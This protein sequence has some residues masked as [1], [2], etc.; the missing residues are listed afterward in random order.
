MKNIRLTRIISKVNLPRTLSKNL[1]GKN[2]SAMHRKLFGLTIMLAGITIIKLTAIVSIEIVR[3]LGE[4]LGGGVHG[5]GVI[6]FI[7]Q[8][9][10]EVDEI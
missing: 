10:K 9:D 8:I 5:I 4:T 6:P 2:H 3:F 7:S 1:V